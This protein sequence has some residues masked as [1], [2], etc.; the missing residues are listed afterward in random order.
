M[1]VEATRARWEVARS[2]CSEHGRDVST[3]SLSH[4]ITVCCATDEAG[5]ASRAE[6]IGRDVDDLRANA[7]AGTPQQVAAR[8]GEY[9]AAGAARSYLQIIDLDDLAH[10]ELIATEVMPLLAGV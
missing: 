7:A 8:L 10:I 6:R 4:A 2:W 5:L 1:T 9:R 3:L